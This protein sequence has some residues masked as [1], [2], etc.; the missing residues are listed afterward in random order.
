MNPPQKV[1]VATNEYREEMDV[2]SEYMEERCIIGKDRSVPKK[3]LYMDYAEWCED[4]KQRP[5]SYSLFC[6]QL[7]E[8]DYKSSVTKVMF[9]GQ[10]KSIR[11][12]KGITLSHLTRTAESPASAIVSKL[13]WGDA[14]A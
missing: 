5:Q 3:Q 11:V 1:R 8:R 12:W 2:L 9:G 13:K 14:E 7:S 10:R 6:R 4:M